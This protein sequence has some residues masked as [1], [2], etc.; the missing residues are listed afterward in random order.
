MRYLLIYATKT[1]SSR[2]CASL[3]AANLNAQDC[4]VVDIASGQPDLSGF[5]AFVAGSYVRMGKMDKRIV[6]FIKKHQDDM[7]FGIFACGCYPQNFADAALRNLGDDI[8]EKAVTCDFLGA[9][10][11]VENYKG[12]DRT[13][14]KIMVAT[15]EKDPS[16]GL[17]DRVLTER[18]PVF[19]DEM[20]NLDV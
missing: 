1:G 7:P 6:S 3:I 4:E 18:I 5:D 19:A 8:L 20:R 12:L 16:F 14:A 10:L 2:R 11:I 15:K 17:C 13:M 9:D